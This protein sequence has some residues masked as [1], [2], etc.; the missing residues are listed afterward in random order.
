MTT[1]ISQ[2]C[3]VLLLSLCV[4]LLLHSKIRP[5][6]VQYPA[7]SAISINNIVKKTA[8]CFWEWAGLKPQSDS[9]VLL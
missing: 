1:D 7:Q 5:A 3:L 9:L 2:I 4:D 6:V 8:S